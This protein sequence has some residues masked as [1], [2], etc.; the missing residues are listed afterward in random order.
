L[1]RKALERMTD[2]ELKAYEAALRRAVEQEESLP[3]RI[4]LS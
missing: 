2:E 4:S 1:S 3:R